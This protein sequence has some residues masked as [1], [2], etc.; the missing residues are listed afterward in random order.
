VT[1]GTLLLGERLDPRQWVGAVIVL[2]AIL[3]ILRQSVVGSEATESG[4]T[5]RE[6]LT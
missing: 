5:S 1:A 3:V 6:A 2:A 4:A